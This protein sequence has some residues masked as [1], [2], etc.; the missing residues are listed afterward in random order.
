MK[1][2]PRLDLLDY[3]NR[4][5]EVLRGRYGGQTFKAGFL[6]IAERYKGIRSGERRLNVDDVMAIF[7][8]DLPFGQDWTKPDRQRLQE[9]MIAFR[10]PD[11]IYRL[12]DRMDGAGVLELLGQIREALGDLSLAAL[13]LHHAYPSRFAMCSHHLASLLYIVNASTVPKFYFAYCEEL[14]LWGKE[15]SSR[16]LD[17]VQTEYALWTWYRLA[18]YGKN[19]EKRKNKDNFF[20]DP[21]VQNRRA[22]KVSDALKGLGRLDIARSYV[23]VDANLAATIAWVEFEHSIRTLVPPDR[24]NRAK[25]NSVL[26]L[27]DKL[28]T[29]ALPRRRTDLKHLWLR[30]GR[31]RNEVIHQ[32]LR[33]TS[34]EANEIVNEVV[35]FVAF[36]F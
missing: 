2:P 23:G 22:L 26:D 20:K 36:N 25:E 34:D 3:L 8:D 16:Q 9:R 28:P 11:A 4:F 31:G 18:Y 7:D 1:A 33:L 12:R 6:S 5:D 13:V 24:M 32:G 30:K 17:V 19:E 35:D 29:G 27:I 10:V 14:K 21:W 15:K